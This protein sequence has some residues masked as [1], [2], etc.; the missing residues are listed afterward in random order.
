MRLLGVFHNPPLIAAMIAWSL[1]QF[2]K[3]S[4]SMP[5]PKVE[6]GIVL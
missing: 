5:K 2:I 1:A 4:W 6:L 3:P